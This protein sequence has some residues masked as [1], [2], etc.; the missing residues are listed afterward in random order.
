MHAHYFLLGHTF[1][2]HYPIVVD[3]VHIFPFS[4]NIWME[5][6]VCPPNYFLR[7]LVGD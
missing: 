7:V 3:S 5:I 1:L 6:Y 4:H 2:N